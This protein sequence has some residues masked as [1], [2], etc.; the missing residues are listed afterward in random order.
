[1]KNLS[2][3][4]ALALFALVLAPVTAFADSHQAFTHLS[5]RQSTLSPAAAAAR[6]T[7]NKYLTRLAKNHLFMGS[8]LVADANGIVL[9]K[10]YGFSNWEQHVPNAPGTKFRL[11]DATL[12]FTAAA[13][14]QLK[15]EGKLSLQD[16]ACKYIA[17]CPPAWSDVT[18]Q[19]LLNHT[20]GIPNLYND[21]ITGF[22]DWKYWTPAQ[23]IGFVQNT[24]LLFK[25]GTDWHYSEINYIALG[26]VIEQA[27]GQSFGTYLQD[28]LF[29][30]LGMAN[31]G[32]AQ[33]GEAV[34][35]L[36][37]GYDGFPR[38]VQSMFN[39]NW[40]FSAGGVYSTVGDLYLW[41][42]ALR[43]EKLVSKTSLDAMLTPSFAFSKDAGYG[44]GWQI[45]NYSGHHLIADG[46]GM[47]GVSTLNALFPD[48]GVTIILLTNNDQTAMDVIFPYVADAVL[49][50]KGSQ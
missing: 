18:I 16:R 3:R 40:T 17:S 39:P 22:Y 43:T 20:S 36:A 1:M 41:D 33:Q 6:L 26:L 7:I 19:Q 34:P 32:L 30:P 42:Q 48:D 25:P 50:T 44:Y 46:G 47:P 45:Q 11:S 49:G 31:S 35:G 23:I 13:V 28:H 38:V 21:G 9:D 8:V 37:R 15:D 24:P 5:L 10:G 4:L 14:L 27:S 2:V 12:Q 29:R